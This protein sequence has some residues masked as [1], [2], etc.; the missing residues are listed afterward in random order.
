MELRLKHILKERNLS[1]ADF[2]AMSGITKANLSNYMSGK[3]SPKLD[4]LNKI[5]DTLQVPLTELFQEKEDIDVAFYV[6]Y[7]GQLVEI[8]TKDM[9]KIATAKTQKK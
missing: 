1:L 6:K 2:S 3:I 8:T 9:L 4:T 7:N 5:A